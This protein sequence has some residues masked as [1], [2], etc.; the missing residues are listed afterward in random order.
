M[1][2]KK[3]LLLNAAILLIVITFNVVISCNKKFDTPPIYIPPNITANTTIA[4]LKAVHTSGHADSI[5]TDAIIAGV[6]IANDSSGNF[7]KQIIIQ[8]S[9][10]GIAVSIDD[11]NLYTS[12]PIGRKVYVQLNGLYINDD[13]GLIYLGTSP[14]AG[15]RLTGIPSRLKDKYLIK[16]ELHI[17][18]I[19]AD[20]TVQDLKSDNDK[21]AY[22]LI[23][24]NNFEVKTTDTAKTYANAV[25]KT[26][27]SI[28]VKNC[29]G[30]TM[31]VRS[32]G[33]AAFAGIN[34]PNGNGSL[35]A[36][37][38][39]YK[40]AYNS[41]ITPQIMIRDTADMQFAGTRCGGNVPPANGALIS[42]KEL[43]AMYNGSDIKLGAYKIGGVVI[44]DA[45]NKNVSNGS[46]VLQ[47][48][49]RGIS[50]YFG[51]T[52]TYN[53]GDSIVLDVNNDSLINYRGSLEIKTPYGTAKPTAVATGIPVFPKETTIQQLKDSLSN[54]E[55]TLVKIKG[56]TASGSTTYSGSQMLTDASGNI[57]L[58]TSPSAAFAGSNLPGSAN[59]WTGYGSFY[60]ATPQ[61]QIRNISDVAGAMVVSPT[62]GSDLLI[63]EYVEGSSNNKYL[64]IYNA[65]AAAADLSK[66]HIKLYTNGHDAAHGA[67]NSGRLDSVSGTASLAPGAL[68]VFSTTAASLTLPAGVVAYPT[69]VCNFNG[70]DAITL[71]KNGVVID[72]FG[73][74]GTDP[75]TSWTIAGNSKAA[76]DKTVRRKTGI[77]QGNTDWTSSAANE[78]IVIISINDVSDL[79]IR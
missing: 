51:G 29:A 53:I 8:D 17:P 16:G 61:F 35:T 54:V 5:E 21:Y 33:Y 23:R 60:N 31:V 27:A 72:V 79:G 7:Y 11:N 3:T 56:A 52:V 55:F 38:V 39:Y 47:D 66:Y 59:D 57:T 58:Y 18:I 78:W 50:V 43:R 42:I 34:V 46:V 10:A 73:D 65:G 67:D 2:T 77:I 25:N 36:V 4:A 48:G 9:T 28:T 68:L 13:G 44:S 26:D 32:S 75:G 63:S 20:V 15:G 45:D 62:G 49:D 41:R 19:P 71:E 12:F 24:L 40:S 64:E 70:N 74:V 37:Y 69:S 76:T 1:K 30:D 22:T 14:D 6:V